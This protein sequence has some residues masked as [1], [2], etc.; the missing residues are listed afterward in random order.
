MATSTDP[1]A[2]TPVDTKRNGPLP[3]RTIALGTVGSLLIL[4]GALGAAGIL[5]HDPMLGRGPLSWLRYGHGQM[6]A[7]MVVYIGFGLVVWAWVRVGRYVLDERIRTRAV[8]IAAACWTAPLVISPPLFTRDVYSYIA[9]GALPLEG[10]DPYT[11]GPAVLHNDA[12]AVNVDPFWQTNPAPYGPLF[13][14]AA[15]GV[16]W[17]TGSDMIAGVIL[18]R[19][20][21]M[22][23]LALL[24]AATPTLTRH[25]GGKLPVAMWLV[26]AGPMTVVHLVGGP[27]NDLLMVGFLAAGTALVL[28]G[29]HALGIIVVTLGAAVKATA[30]VA[31]P[32]LIWVW[33]N[34]LGST[35]WRN[36]TKAVA[37]GLAL[38]AATFA[39]CTFIAGVDLG[40]IMA[41]DAPGKIVNWLSV[42]TAVGQILHGLIGIF[43]TIPEV[44]VVSVTR[45]IGGVLIVVILVRQWW[46]ARD[47]GPDAVRRAAIALFAVAMLSP[48]TLPWYLAAP[49]VLAAGLAFSRRQLAMMV[50]FA[51]FLVLTYSPSG[52]DLLYDWLFMAGAIAVSV[53]AGLAL[54]RP[55]P[56]RL[57]AGRDEFVRDGRSVEH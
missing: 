10:F 50:S 23:G 31:L 41:L 27:H 36:F 24:I 30:V 26:V 52:H 7:T 11:F 25:L 29:K 15:K 17:I 2:T 12:V 8:L 33:A 9:I 35:R 55:D 1:S 32:F 56:L 57:F 46:L 51:V 43:V 49:L 34:R 40:W 45:V 5:V 3:V 42:P 6:L 37:A 53:L 54:L 19:I 4:L 21:L 28:N 48:A 16:A 38:F 22:A 39:A 44:W 47:G 20:V 18:S 14:L 13:I